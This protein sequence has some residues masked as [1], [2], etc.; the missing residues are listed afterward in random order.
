VSGMKI[1]VPGGH[2]DQLWRQTR[3]HHVQLSMMADTK[4][5]MLITVSAITLPLTLQLLHGGDR[6]LRYA[7]ITLSFFCIVTACLAA[8]AAMPKILQSKPDA[9]GRLFN[10]LF[11]ADFIH[12]SYD[13]FLKRAEEM[14]ANPGS[15]HEAQAREVYAMGQYLAARKYKYVRLGYMAFLAGLIASGSVW[16]VVKIWIVVTT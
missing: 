15:A 16:V 4:A 5:N 1:E 3:N 13:E 11:F 8:Y 14:S 12:L 9:T 10:P 7:A 2:V 6:A